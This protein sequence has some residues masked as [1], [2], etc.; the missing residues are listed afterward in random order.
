M[1]ARV[2]RP[3]SRHP[4]ECCHLAPGTGAMFA[5][6]AV[7]A[8][9]AASGWERVERRTCV[10]DDPPRVCLRAEPDQ[11]IWMKIGGTRAVPGECLQGGAHSGWARVRVVDGTGVV[12]KRIVWARVGRTIELTKTE[13]GRPRVSARSRC[14]LP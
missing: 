7:T 14:A 3:R 6:V 11:P 13:L 8:C 12:S 1:L 5:L 2:G 4:G 10:Q 9:A